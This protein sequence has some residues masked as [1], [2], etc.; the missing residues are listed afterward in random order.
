MSAEVWA[1][2]I[3]EE[4]AEYLATGCPRAFQELRESFRRYFHSLK[5]ADWVGVA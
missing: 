3:A 5:K 4:Q 2:Y 1:L